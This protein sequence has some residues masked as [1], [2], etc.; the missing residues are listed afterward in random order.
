RAKRVRAAPDRRLVSVLRL[1]GHALPAGAGRARVARVAA[2]AAVERV[3]RRVHAVGAAQRAVARV[4][5]RA[6]VVSGRRLK[7][8]VVVV[9]AAVAAFA[10]D[11]AAVLVRGRRVARPVGSGGASDDETRG[12]ADEGDGFHGDGVPSV[13]SAALQRSTVKLPI[14]SGTPAC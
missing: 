7:A 9:G 1:V 8:G 6:A 3:A 5:V 4:L 10:D 12:N 11:S 14:S 2:R 13:N